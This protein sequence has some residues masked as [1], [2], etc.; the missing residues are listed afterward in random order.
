MSDDRQLQLEGRPAAPPPLDETP[1]RVP[2]PVRRAEAPVPLATTPPPAPATAPATKPGRLRRLALMV[3]VPALLL[4]GGGYMWLTGGRYVATDNAYVQQRMVVIAPEISGAVIA[5]DV[6]ENQTVAAGD[7]LFRIDPEPYRIALAQAEAALANARVSVEQLRAAYNTAEA[8]L[9][10][11]TG[12]LDIRNR[13]LDRLKTLNAQG[14]ASSSS[15]DDVTLAAQSAQNEVALAREGLATAAAAL[16]GD[17]DIRTEDHP[18][19]IAA[20]AQRDLASRNLAK[21]T[22]VAPVAG[23]VSQVASLNVGRWVTPGA[24]AASLVESDQ[25]WVEANF[26]ETQLAGLTVGQPVHVSVDAYPGLSLEGHVESIGAA[27]GAEFALLPAQNATGNWVKVVQRVPVRIA[28]TPD[29]EHDLR[30]GMSAH[31]SVDTGKS[32]LDSLL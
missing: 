24:A 13:E 30:L 32:R 15:L 28:V 14:V 1:S 21:T 27:T 11:A 18:L 29:S 5:V 6:A 31:V 17:P 2:A 12:I 19:V 25:S 4:V 22:V 8:K 23:I 26:K 20:L 9:T 10:A 7:T 3:V 16:G